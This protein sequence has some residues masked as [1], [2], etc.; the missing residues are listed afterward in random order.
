MVV[1][2]QALEADGVRM[3]HE[4]ETLRDGHHCSKD[5]EGSRSAPATTVELRTSKA[6]SRFKALLWK[7]FLWNWRHPL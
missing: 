6:S 2:S 4:L 1:F 7:N 3:D 5:E